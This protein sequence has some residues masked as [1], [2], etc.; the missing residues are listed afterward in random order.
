MLN[1]LGRQNHLYDVRL[2]NVKPSDLRYAFE[3][4]FGINHDIQAVYV[5]FEDT[6]VTRFGYLW[7]TVA[8]T[9]RYILST[10]VFTRENLRVWKDIGEL[11]KNYKVMEI[12]KRID[13][14]LDVSEGVTVDMAKSFGESLT[15]YID[16][17]V[18]Q[19]LRAYSGLR[20][21]M[22]ITYDVPEVVEPTRN[23]LKQ[24]GI[25]FNRT[26]MNKVHS[27]ENGIMTK[28]IYS[29]AE[30]ID[31]WSG[32]AMLNERMKAAAF[33]AA[34]DSIGVDHDQVLVINDLSR[35]EFGI[36]GLVPPQ[37]VVK[38]HQIRRFAKSPEIKALV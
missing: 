20:E 2:D 31:D 4:K 16:G 21:K 11:I 25:N 13:M 22:L 24:D 37:N 6:I 5:D 7:R 19:L 23:I 17:N 12:D 9:W 28:D 35:G 29:V 27:D 30:N 3:E 1:V 8:E 36:D 14:I 38:S 18:K 34:V 15:G 32:P 10:F 33:D 26:I